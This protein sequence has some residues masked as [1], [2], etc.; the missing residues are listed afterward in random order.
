MK[1]RHEARGDASADEPQAKRSCSFSFEAQRIVRSD[2][3][4]LTQQYCQDDLSNLY[5]Y[6]SP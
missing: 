5:T 2:Q 3:V 4:G 6:N 1:R